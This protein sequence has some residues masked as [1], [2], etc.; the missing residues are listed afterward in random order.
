MT[1]PIDKGTWTTDNA[2]TVVGFTARHL[3]F[4]KVHGRFTDHDIKVNVGDTLE[5]SSV[6]ASINLFSVETGNADRDGHLK[7][8]D[9]FG[10][11]DNPTMEFVS[12]SIKGSPEDFTIVGD[13]TIN[14][15]TLPVEFA[16]AFEGAN[17][18][19][20]ATHAAFEASAEI[21]RTDWD[22]T[23]NMPVGEKL[24]VS[25]KIKVRLDTELVKA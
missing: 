25:E 10:G 19:M 11:S 13:L 3:G 7:S 22:I 24:A 1:L 20:D 18:F 16:A 14:G 2:H 9:F 5:D 12:T 21:N 23:W 15:K 4:T 17:E 6:S 8:A